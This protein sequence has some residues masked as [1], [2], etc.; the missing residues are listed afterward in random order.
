[1]IPGPSG[2][3]SLDP[4]QPGNEEVG[5]ERSTELELGFDVA[6]LNDRISSEFSWYSRATEGA[7]LSVP[8]PP[9]EGFS[10]SVQRNLGELANWGWEV[11]VDSEIY[12]SPAFSFNLFVSGSYTMNEIRSLGDFPGTK[13][14]RIGYPYPSHRDRYVVMEATEVAAGTGTYH[15]SFGEEI[16]ALCDSG[17]PLAEGLG[18]GWAR[19][20]IVDPLL[21]EGQ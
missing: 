8:L 11:S 9:H 17:V 21:R 18:A 16:N 15:N 5:P 10:G 12:Q 6:L 13:E 20:G 4:S 2:T 14:I 19:G 1:M 3:T 7:L